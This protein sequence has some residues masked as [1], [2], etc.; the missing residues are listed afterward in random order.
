MPMHVD[1]E[2]FEAALSRLGRSIDLLTDEL[3]LGNESQVE[4]RIEEVRS[5][6]AMVKNNKPSRDLNITPAEYIA[7]YMEKCSEN[8]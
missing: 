6:M 1:V 7:E 8:L 2:T 3:R 5:L 4:Q